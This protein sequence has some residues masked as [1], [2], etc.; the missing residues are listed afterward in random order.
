MI[1]LIVRVL[2]SMAGVITGWF[3]ARDATNFDLIQMAVAI[4]LM[5]FFLAGAAFWPSLLAWF[6]HRREPQG[7]TN[8]R[9]VRQPPARPS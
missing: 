5:I 1:S 6:R 7:R 8:P 2:L 3:V 4:L 9:G